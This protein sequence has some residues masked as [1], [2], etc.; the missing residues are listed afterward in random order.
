MVG[1]LFQLTDIQWVAEE[2]ILVDLYQGKVT[3][4]ID[5]I[6]ETAFL[7]LKQ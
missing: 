5:K 6:E 2:K 7:S 3:K 4:D 1:T